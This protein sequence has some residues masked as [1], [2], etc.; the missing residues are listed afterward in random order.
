MVVETSGTG[1]SGEDQGISR[2]A[3]A[4]TAQICGRAA[5]HMARAR[6]ALERESLDPGQA[7]AQLDD[8]ISC[9]Q[10]LPGRRPAAKEQGG[11]TVVAFQ[12]AKERRSA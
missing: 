10:S 5:E 2:A 11:D 6:Q 8:A 4:N 1:T 7:L 3:K 9:L 12:A